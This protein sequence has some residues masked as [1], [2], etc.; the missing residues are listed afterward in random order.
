[1]KKIIS[2]ALLSLL[3]ACTSVP[4]KSVVERVVSIS[5][6]CTEEQY[7]R[8]L[9]KA[10]L[11]KDKATGEALLRAGLCT[12]LPHTEV[13]LVAVLESGK[14]SDG[15][16][17]QLVKVRGVDGTGEYFAV[18]WPVVDEKKRPQA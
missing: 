10:I 11:N 1:M 7:T 15:D 4:D 17:F 12:P 14:D 6:V 9:Y 8:I 13:K 5:G 2:V 16:V 18:Y 3:L